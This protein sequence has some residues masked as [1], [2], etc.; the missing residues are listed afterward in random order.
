MPI[1]L[2]FQFQVGGYLNLL[3]GTWTWLAIYFLSGIYG[4]ILR[5]LIH[6]PV[7]ISVH[8]YVHQYICIYM[9]I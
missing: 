2:S 9:Y 7:A 1:Q 6:S 5:L 3:Y 4:E 8:L